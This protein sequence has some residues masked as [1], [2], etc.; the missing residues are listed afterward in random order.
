MFAIVA[1]KLSKV[2][3][4]FTTKSGRKVSLELFVDK[5]NES[6]TEHAL[7]SLKK[8][9]E[10]DEKVFGLEYDLDLYMIV[11]VDAFNMGAMENKGLNI[12]NS[13]Y[14]LANPQ[15]AT[16]QD[17]HNIEAV[18]AHEYFHNWTGNRVTCR[19][20]FQLT[21]KEGLTVFRD[22]EFSSDMN[23]RSTERINN[24]TQLRN[25]QF[26]EDSSPLAHP[27]KP[28]SYIEINN[29]YTYTIYNKGSEIIRMIHTLIGNDMFRKGMDLYFKRH[30]GKAVTTDDFLEAMATVSKHDF[31]QFKHWYHQAGTPHCSLKTHY[32]NDTSTYQ[33]TVTQS[34]RPTPET[35]TKQPFY[36][37]LKLAFYDNEGKELLNKTI[38]ISKP[39]ETFFFPSLP[40]TAIPSV[41]RDFS[42]PV[43]Y[44]INTTDKDKL[45]LLHYDTNNFSRYEMAQELLIKACLTTIDTNTTDSF[46]TLINALGQFITPS[47]PDLSFCSQILTFPS[48]TTLNNRLPIHDYEA[49]Y[50]A[51]ER[52]YQALVSEFEEQLITCYETLN[53]IRSTTITPESV[54]QRKLKNKC[55]FLLNFSQNDHSQLMLNQLKKAENMTDEIAAIAA[56]SYQD[57]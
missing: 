54:A 30:D 13:H 27:I 22:Q 10:W 49:T 50:I 21:L 53:Q 40:K 55:L 5:G 56:L 39:S 45:H 14:V 48:L 18:I 29:F 41:F 24:V 57:S 19:D 1:G 52:C 25:T 12:F 43:T 20:W 36:F 2:S 37:P 47:H 32:D 16:D 35:T 51:R 33:L 15:T 26:I 6:K 38:I 34:C 46:S 8:S 3:D 28:D 11:A 4:Y 42:A 31:S 23:S 7:T 9:M 44:D 17:Y